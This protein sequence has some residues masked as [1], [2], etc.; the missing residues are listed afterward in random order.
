MASVH[1]RK[2]K[3]GEVVSYQVKWRLGGARNGPWQTE[4]FD[5]EVSAGVFKEAVDEAGQQWPPGWIKGRGYI[6]QDAEQPDQ[7]RYRFDAFAVNSVENRT[8]IEEHY[9][10][11]CMRD[12]ERWILPTFGN[13]DVR[14]TEHFSRDTVRAWVRMLEQT[15]VFSGQR[16]KSGE[17]KWRPMSPKTIRNLHGLLS[18]ILQ[19]AVTA[20]PPLRGRNPCAQTALPRTDDDGAEDGE[21]IEFLTPDEVEGMISCMERRSDQLLTIVGY[22]TGMRWGEITALAPMCVLDVDTAAP[23]VRVRRAWKKDGKGGYYIGKP[24]SKRSRRTLR[25]S[26]GVLDALAELGLRSLDRDALFFT[27]ET[28]QRLHYSTFHDR[29]KRAVRRAKAEGLLPS[30]KW[31]T[32]HDLRHSHAAALLSTGSHSLTYVQRRLGHESIK[33]TS[34]TYGHLLPEAD[35]EA[36][37]TIEASLGR[38]RS[39]GHAVAGAAVAGA[40]TVVH[41]VHLGDEALLGFWDRAH[42]EETAEQWA[43]ERR[44]PVR[45]EAC[46]VDWWQRTVPGGANAVRTSVP[47][48]VWLWEAGPTVYAADGTEVVGALSGS[49]PRAGWAWEWEERYTQEAACMAVEW[50]PGPRAETEARAWGVEEA[51]VRSVYETARTEALRVCAS[52]PERTAAGGDVEA[53]R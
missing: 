2:D 44:R 28:G 27:G 22:G 4:R 10:K 24:K 21:D 5:D 43:G 1:P 40:R 42:A 23:K 34:D 31:P 36:M 6:V 46:A 25:V 50:R 37:A 41:A 12:L 16:P 14:S 15:K 29:W 20:D 18:S 35:D 7:D 19:E 17:P 33:T 30:E 13:C 38:G 52:H 8:G 49:A 26:P 39:H 3:A 51:A 48:R 32:P 9:R 11:A 47:A 53:A 45:M